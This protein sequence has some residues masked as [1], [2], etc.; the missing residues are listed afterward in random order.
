MTKANPSSGWL[1]AKNKSFSIC[2][3]FLQF[4]CKIHANFFKNF[5]KLMTQLYNFKTIWLNYKQLDNLPRYKNLQFHGCQGR[6]AP[7]E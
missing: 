3:S 4:C 6:Q 2:L 7:P 1:F 5:K